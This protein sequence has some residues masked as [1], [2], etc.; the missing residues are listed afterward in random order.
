MT[1]LEYRISNRLDHVL[2]KNQESVSRLETALENI[3]SDTLK[4]A[5]RSTLV[6]RRKHIDNLENEIYK[7]NNEP[8]GGTSLAATAQNVWINF[9]SNV[10]N[11]SDKSIVVECLSGEKSLLDDYKLLLMDRDLDKQLIARLKEQQQ[12]IS[13]DISSLE[14]L[15]EA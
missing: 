1:N 5:L 15:V 12:H 14:R 7:L 2:S 6:V 3:A 13:T 9:K 8:V 10:L 11:S 4:Q